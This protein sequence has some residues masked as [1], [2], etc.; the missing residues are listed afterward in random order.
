MVGEMGGMAMFPRGASSPT[1]SRRLQVA[2]VAALPAS[3]IM[4]RLEKLHSKAMKL[5]KTACVLHEHV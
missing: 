1:A 2:E 3:H 5:G 4:M